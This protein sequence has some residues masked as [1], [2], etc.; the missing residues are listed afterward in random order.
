MVCI[1][2]D[3]A[4]ILWEKLCVVVLSLVVRVS[5]SCAACWRC[6]KC[7]N[8]CLVLLTAIAQ[9]R[10]PAPVSRAPVQVA[11]MAKICHRELVTPTEIRKNTAPVTRQASP[12]EITHICHLWPNEV[13]SD[14]RDSLHPRSGVL[15]WCGLGILSR[16][17]VKKL[18]ILVILPG[19]I[20][21]QTSKCCNKGYCLPR[22]GWA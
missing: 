7:V 21:P 1:Y 18:C 20:C 19:Q 6:C 2:G 3:L 15:T 22:A 9:H 11:T 14:D 10:A 8:P 5:V 17:Q 13:R 16:D 4:Y 12:N